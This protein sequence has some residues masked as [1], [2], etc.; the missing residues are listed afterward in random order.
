MQLMVKLFGKKDRK[1]II[2]NTLLFIAGIALGTL[3]GIFL[4]Q[5]SEDGGQALPTDTTPAGNYD[6]E[7][8]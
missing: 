8:V 1:R 2:I 7:A 3:L 4:I 6:K 5:R